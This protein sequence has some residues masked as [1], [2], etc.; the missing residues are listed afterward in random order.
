MVHSG[1]QNFKFPIVFKNA[2]KKRW[3]SG[4]RSA[5]EVKK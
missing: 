1:D 5:V 4:Y 2:G 3:A